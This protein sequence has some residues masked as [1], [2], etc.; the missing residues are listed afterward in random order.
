MERNICEKFLNLISDT[1]DVRYPVSLSSHLFVF[2]HMDTS[3]YLSLC[4]FRDSC[5]SG[6]RF[7]YLFSCFWRRQQSWCGDRGAGEG[8]GG[9][10]GDRRGEEAWKMWGRKRHLHGKEKK[11]GKGEEKKDHGKFEIIFRQPRSCV[12]IAM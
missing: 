1:H 4:Y 10:A 12:S 5:F 7:I 3:I 6:I 11:E 8:G 2:L 9:W